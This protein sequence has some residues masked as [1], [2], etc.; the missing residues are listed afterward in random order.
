MGGSYGCNQQLPEN[1]RCTNTGNDGRNIV[2]EC[3]SNLPTN[4]KFGSTI[5]GCEG[6]DS[7]ND[8]YILQDSCGVSNHVV[9]HST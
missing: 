4:V 7:P 3:T 2:W 5:V 6:Y 9:L 1:V 8:P